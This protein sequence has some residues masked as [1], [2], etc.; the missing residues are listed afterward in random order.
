MAKDYEI[1]QGGGALPPYGEDFFQR[2]VAVHWPKKEALLGEFT[3][4]GSGQPLHA[5]YG[6]SGWSVNGINWITQSNISAGGFNV[7]VRGDVNQQDMLMAGGFKLVSIGTNADHSPAFAQAPIVAI[8][9]D[10]LSWGDSGL[11]IVEPLGDTNPLGFA[12]LIRQGQVYAIGFDPKAKVFF[13]AVYYL[14]YDVTQ[15][16]V[17]MYIYSGGWTLDYQTIVTSDEAVTD[18]F[19]LPPYPPGIKLCDTGGGS[20]FPTQIDPNANYCSC[21][22]SGQTMQFTDA[23]DKNHTLE[24]GGGG[25]TIDGQ[26]VSVPSPPFSACAGKGI[27]A[28]VV[29]GRG[30]VSVSSDLGNSW[31]TVLTSSADG[32]PG[33]VSFS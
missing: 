7:S 27:I 4:G 10:G 32:V 9:T 21:N 22:V 8:S 23:T 30:N 14:N 19:P 16:E 15:F 26:S 17:Y 29:G 6:I 25:L 18:G 13:A 31:D 11:P 12:K 2:V 28:V 1:A 33:T 20:G 24:L 3:Y 5:V